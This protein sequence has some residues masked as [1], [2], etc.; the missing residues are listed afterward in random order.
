VREPVAPDHLP[1]V[2]VQRD[3]LRAVGAR[4]RDGAGEDNRPSATIGND[5]APPSGAVQARVSV[6]LAVL[7]SAVEP[8]RVGFI[9]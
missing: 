5:R 3:D 8:S 6:V 9:W 4:A 2:R 7:P 1:R